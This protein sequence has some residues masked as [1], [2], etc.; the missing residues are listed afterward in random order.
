MGVCALAQCLFLCGDSTIGTMSTR[1]K[2]SWSL[3]NRTNTLTSIC[4]L[5]IATSLS[6]PLFA[7]D[8]MHH[9]CGAKSDEKKAY[10]ATELIPGPLQLVSIDDMRNYLIEKYQLAGITVNCFSYG[11]DAK[12]VAITVA[13]KLRKLEIQN[14]SFSLKTTVVDWP[15]K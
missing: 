13:E 10:Y 2:E 8:T 9:F 4:A 5:M 11:S 14:N 3:I 6:T 12:P 1:G 7:S 15:H